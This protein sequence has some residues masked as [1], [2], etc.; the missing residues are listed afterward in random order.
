MKMKTALRMKETKELDVDVVPG[1]VEFP[2][3]Q[4]NVP[5]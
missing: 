5:I 1:A 3:P 4:H 2:T